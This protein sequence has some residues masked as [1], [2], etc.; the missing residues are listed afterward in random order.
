VDEIEVGRALEARVRIAVE[1]DDLA[2]AADAV[3]EAGGRALAP[4]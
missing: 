3:T 2:E 4:R 1:V